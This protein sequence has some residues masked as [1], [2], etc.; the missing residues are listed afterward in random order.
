MIIRNKPRMLDIIFAMRGSVLPHIARPLISLIVIA[1]ALVWVEDAYGGLP[2]VDATPFT[3][4]GI[5]LSLFLGFRNNAAYDRWWEARRLWGGL[6][7][8]MRAFA[9]EVRIFVADDGL[10]LRMLELA[11]TFIHL[12]RASLRRRAGQLAADGD[13][14]LFLD[15]PHPPDAALDRL[16]ELMAEALGRGTIDGFGART[17][18]AR[19]GSFALQQAGCERIA[20][21]PLPYVYSLLIYR[22][23][24]LYCVLLPLALIGPAGWLTPLFVGIAA[25]VFLGLAEVSEELSQPFGDNVN[26]LPLDAICRAAEISLAPHMGREAPSPILPQGYHLA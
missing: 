21:T 19:L 11:L 1:A 2:Q 10:R 20:G 8:D 13:I 3:V 23:T 24:Y 26:A 7:A 6:L 4:F 15:A 18:S 9:R 5:A 22:T 14:A 25:Y 16:G 12:H 17:L